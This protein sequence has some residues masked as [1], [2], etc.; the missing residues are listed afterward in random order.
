MSTADLMPASATSTPVSASKAVSTTRPTHLS[1][2]LPQRYLSPNPALPLLPPQRALPVQLQHLHQLLSDLDLLCL[3]WGNQ[4]RLFTPSNTNFANINLASLN[5]NTATTTTTLS[6]TPSSAIFPSIRTPK[7]VVLQDLTVQCISPGLPTF[8][9][10]IRDAMAKSKSIQEAQRKI[11]AQRMK[12]NGSVTGSNISEGKPFSGSDDE[13]DID[14]EPSS[15]DI[16]NPSKPSKSPT[17]H[18]EPLRTANSHA[19]E[20]D[21]T[22]SNKVS[23]SANS[24]NNANFNSVPSNNANPETSFSTTLPNHKTSSRDSPS[25]ANKDSQAADDNVTVTIEHSSKLLTIVLNYLNHLPSPRL[26]HFQS[27][28]LP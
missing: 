16:N 17:A 1:P 24:A 23:N 20:R 18:A 25:A 26:A 6:A 15:E 5:R 9:A 8:P 19:N 21:E 12:D 27:P 14:L 2:L 10:T 13:N 11:I 28:L 4:Q 7:D 22:E 3:F